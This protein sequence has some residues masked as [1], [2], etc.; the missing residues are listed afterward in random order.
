[1]KKKI[2]QCI[3]PLCLLSFNTSKGQP[4]EIVKA[5]EY[6]SSL[7]QRI[8]ADAEIFQATIKPGV[9]T[10][11]FLVYIRPNQ[12]L[13]VGSILAGGAPLVSFSVLGGTAVFT[14]TYNLGGASLSNQTQV[15]GG[16]SRMVVGTSSAT[17][18]TLPWIAN[19]ERLAYTINIAA[20]DTVGA[21]LEYD[22]D[23]VFS[24]YVADQ[25]TA[26][27]WTNYSDPFYTGGA[28]SVEGVDGIFT[29]VTIPS[30]SGTLPVTFSS[31]DVKCTDKGV[32]LTW[33]TATEQNSSRFEI[34]RTENGNDWVTIDNVLAA[35]NSSDNR[36]Y[37]YLDLKG[38]FAQY[39]IKQVDNDGRF[40]YT[41]IKRT[42]CKQ[43]EF[44]VLL[45]P[46]PAKDN[47]TVV[48]KSDRAVRTDLQI[49][50]MNGRVVRRVS[51]QINKGN[52]NVN[53]NVSA[54]PAGQYMLSGSESSLQINKK[55]TIVR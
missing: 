34:Q 12:S 11:Q 10:T 2:I 5:K 25:P 22:G 3:L 29:Y 8:V 46:V 48:V 47:I 39:R 36:S 55:F 40:V 27:N 4:Q 50:D 33:A 7:G 51:A 28:G 17:N 41:A 26:S 1:M 44:D 16:R 9:N 24:F 32:A 53:L 19:E 21:R 23:L 20:D 14:P 37:Q 38:G 13:P 52:T 31:Y 15:A 18:L 6:Y 30:S 54:L 35:G 45:Y 43:S 49:L 42:N